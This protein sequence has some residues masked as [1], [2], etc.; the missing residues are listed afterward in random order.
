MIQLI[1]ST[2][3]TAVMLCLF[4]LY[5]GIPV[6]IIGAIVL[7]YKHWKQKF[8]PR[9]TRVYIAPEKNA[10]NE[11]DK[12]SAQEGIIDVEFHEVK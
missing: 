6:F 7:A 10:P 4:L 12:T 3:L 9:G 11:G 2:L 8:F 5:V 1:V